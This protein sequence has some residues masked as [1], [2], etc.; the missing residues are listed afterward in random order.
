MPYKFEKLEIWDLS[1]KYLDILYEIARQLPEIE[2]FNL[3]SQLIRA[4]T[5]ISLN[6]AE[7]STGQ[8]DPEQS[9]F[10]GIALRSAIETVACISII[11]R[12]SYISKEGIIQESEP[13]AEILIRKIQA[14][15][16]ALDKRSGKVSDTTVFYETDD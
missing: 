14:M 8:S 10:L 1:L 16:N 15:R 3:R 7:G 4:G 11:K 5:S 12:R 13:K 2:K 6:I 9:R